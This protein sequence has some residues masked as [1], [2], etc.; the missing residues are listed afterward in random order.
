MLYGPGDTLPD[1]KP[2]PPDEDEL[3][4]EERQ[5]LREAEGDRRYHEWAEGER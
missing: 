4:D 3:S 5:D 1:W 2:D